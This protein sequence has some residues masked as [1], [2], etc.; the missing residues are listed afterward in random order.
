MT[1]SMPDTRFLK[2]LI[3]LEQRNC[4]NIDRR[5]AEIDGE[6]QDAFIVTNDLDDRYVEV[7]SKTGLITAHG[8]NED[9]FIGDS[10]CDWV[11][12]LVDEL[13]VS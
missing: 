12:D 13:T 4:P 8:D 1:T 9:E 10:Y 6:V 5:Q 11:Y 3:D 7:C 2:K